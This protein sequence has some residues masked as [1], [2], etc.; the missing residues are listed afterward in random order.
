MKKIRNLICLRH[1]LRSTA[2]ANLEYTF[3]RAHRVPSYHLIFVP[4]FDLALSIIQQT[5]AFSPWHLYEMVTTNLDLNTIRTGGGGVGFRPPPHYGFLPFTQ[6]IFL[7]PIPEIYWLF[8]T[9]ADTPIKFF[10]QKILSTPSD[11]TFV[12]PSTI[13]FCYFLLKSKKSFYKT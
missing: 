9:F 7:Q 12:T 3:K 10:F 4:W 5:S 2:V 8:P 13:I 6:K 11:S 1:L